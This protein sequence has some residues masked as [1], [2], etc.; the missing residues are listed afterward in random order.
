MTGRPY[1][2]IFFKLGVI[3]SLFILTTI[4]NDLY[5]KHM[6]NKG[7]LKTLLLIETFGIALLLLPTGGLLS[8]FIWYALNPILVAAC[9]LPTYFCWMNLI[10]YLTAGSTMSFFLFNSKNLNIITIVMNNYNIVLVF[11]LI[12]LA[13]QLLSNL[14]KKLYIQTDALKVSNMQKQES[15]NYIMSLYQIIEA[16]NNHCTKGKLF[17]TLADY[18]AK[19]T[20]SNLCFFWLPGLKEEEYIIKSN[21]NLK[22]TLQ[23]EINI[24]LHKLSQQCLGVSVQT[25]V[26]ANI[27]L[28]TIPILTPGYPSGLIAIEQMDQLNDDKKVQNIRLLEFLSGLSAVTLERFNLEE[29]ENNLIVMEEQNRIANEIH[30]SV[31]QRLFSISYAIYGVLGKWRDITKEELKEYMVE[32]SETSNLAMQELRNSIYKLSSKKK[33][34]KTLKVTL[35]DFLD[36]ISKLHHVAIDFKIHGDEGLLPMPLKQGITRIIREACGNAIRHGKCG[37]I[38]LVLN[39]KRERISINITDDGIGFIL[40]KEDIEDQKGLGISNIKNIVDSF[41]GIIDIKSQI[42]VGTVIQIKISLNNDLINVQQE[43]IVV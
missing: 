5:I 26:I 6:D 43:G 18:T 33:G 10:F 31:S 8:P 24:E 16:L 36:S 39:I 21:K 35:K 19:L 34:E 32:L 23:Q 12:T 15:I 41:N 7:I 17:E 11:L 40:N 2:I 22:L 28:L 3:G 37:S 27:E 1:S 9:Y 20:S 30:D 25:R 13:V 4:I 42:E 38:Q 29:I 14:T